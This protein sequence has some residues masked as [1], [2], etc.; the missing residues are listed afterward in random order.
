[1]LM[2]F[3]AIG[4]GVGMS[5]GTKVYRHA[6][7]E[8]DSAM[9][10]DTL[11]SSLG[12]VLR[13]CED[14][15]KNPGVFQDSRGEQLMPHQAPFV[16]TNL[17]YGVQDGYLFLKSDGENGNVIQLR[18][19]KNSNQVELINAGAYANLVVT[20]FRMTYVTPEEDTGGNTGY[21]AVSYVIRN[22][23]DS[24]RKEVGTVIR[25]MN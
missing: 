7:F 15:R 5:S 14:L 3:L 9:L 18:N 19:L 2:V 17:E 20:D 21:V 23:N 11:N 13:Y 22:K 16:F 8:T 25:L 4:M 12:D 24:L 6:T 1:V 10:A